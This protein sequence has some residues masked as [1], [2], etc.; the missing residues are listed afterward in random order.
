MLAI[1]D[2]GSTK[3]DWRFLESNN[4][5]L[6][7]TTTGF[8]PNYNSSDQITDILI[9][10]LG[11]EMDISNVSEVFYYGS[12]SSDEKRKKV[13]ASALSAVFPSARINVFSDML[14]AARATCGD[15]PGI[16]CILGTGSN[17]T[18]YDGKHQVDNVTNLG[19]MLGDE[20]SGSYIGKEL[21]KAYFYREMPEEL[22][23]LLKAKCPNGRKDV[24]D[25][26][27]GGGVP[28][29]YLASFTKVF[30]GHQEHPFIRNLI[31]NCF[32]EFIHRHIY[33]YKDFRSLPIHFV[34]SIAF[35]YVNILKEVVEE[36]GLT[37]GKVL[38]KPIDQ[39]LE[40]HLK[41][42]KGSF[43]TGE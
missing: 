5:Y 11:G 4:N 2:G 7:K 28:A 34:G 20:G 14:A 35:H 31:K 24:L 8:N 19:F 25:N 3:A 37:L 43:P 22:T 30:G 42:Q 12:G 13:L 18:L 10:E 6:S 33:K 39:L 21:V 16:A 15:E 32:R 38:Q 26:V 9:A 29:A 17:S 23:H 27:Y 36:E 1:A 40:F 41:H